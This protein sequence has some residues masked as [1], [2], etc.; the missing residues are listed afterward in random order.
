MVEGLGAPAFV[1]FAKVM[2]KL[3][4]KQ[5]RIIIWAGLL[6]MLPELTQKEVYAIIDEY[7]ETHNLED[8]SGVVIQGL[9]E[10]S[11]LGGS[12]ADRGEVKVQ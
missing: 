5:M 12:G 4:P 10:A 9:Q 11:I 6:H 7:L 1:D 2:E 3:G 8:L